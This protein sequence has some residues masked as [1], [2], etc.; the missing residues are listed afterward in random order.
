MQFTHQNY[1]HK[2]TARWADM[3]FKEIEEIEEIGKRPPNT[4]LAPG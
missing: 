3:D 4:L 2:L 1:V